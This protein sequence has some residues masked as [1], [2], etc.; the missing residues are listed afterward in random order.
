[1]TAGEFHF[2]Q[3]YFQFGSESE[4]RSRP[5]QR[6][7]QPPPPAQIATRS[8]SVGMRSIVD[9]G[10]CFFSNNLRQSLR[11]RIGLDFDLRLPCHPL[12]HVEKHGSQK[13]PEDRDT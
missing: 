10:T 6:G 8:Q 12:D 1:M 3:G 9:V 5:S 2:G 7:F 11:C 4:R 13:N